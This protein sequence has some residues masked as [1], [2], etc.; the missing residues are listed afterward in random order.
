MRILVGWD[1]A[2]EGNTLDLLLNVDENSAEIITDGNAFEQAASDGQW[3]VILQA[4]SFPDSESALDLFLRM[5]KQCQD[6]P[7]IGLWRQDE[8]VNLAHFIS[9]GL[10]SHLMRDSDGNYAFLLTSMAAAAKSAADAQRAALLAERLRQ[11]VDSVRLLQESVI[12]NDLPEPDGYKLAARYESSQIHVSG[13]VPVTMAG[14]D[15]YDVFRVGDESLVMLV[16]DAS[17]HGVKACMSIM[18]MHTLIR[19]IQSGQYPKT[20][21]YVTAINNKLCASEIVQD[22]GGFITLLYSMLDLSTNRLHWTS[23]GSPMP[24]LQDLNTNEVEPVAD[25]EKGGLPIAIDEWEYESHY[26]DLPKNSRLLIYTDGLDEAFPP[27]GGEHEQFGLEG[28]IR[29]LKSSADL[30]LNEALE[31]LFADSSEFTRGQGRLDDTS[32]LLIERQA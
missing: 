17:G 8:I 19:M 24:L 18:T 6:V 29:S 21:D 10:H 26:T 1:D 9:A 12:P 11:E 4:L 32:V 14:G 23:A 7:T 3:D 5:R 20:A 30:T 13:V 2:D 16:G 25:D 22:E 31:K 28:I 27:D 15:Y